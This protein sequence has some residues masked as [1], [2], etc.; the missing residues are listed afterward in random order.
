MQVELHFFIS[1]EFLFSVTKVAQNI[2][3]QPVRIFSEHF[4]FLP[5]QRI[6]DFRFQ[7][8]K[9]L[10]NLMKKPYI[11]CTPPPPNNPHKK[12]EKTKI[13]EGKIFRKK[14][15]HD[16]LVGAVDKRDYPKRVYYFQSVFPLNTSRKVGL[17]SFGSTV[18]AVHLST[19]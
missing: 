14:A 4:H 15:L 12:R 19:F 17:F 8:K 13:V 7:Q 9:K 16:Q 6:T 18:I 5:Q 11:T 1:Q 2:L 10:G 3:C